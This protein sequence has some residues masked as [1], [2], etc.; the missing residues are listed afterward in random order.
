MTTRQTPEQGGDEELVLRYTPVDGRCGWLGPVLLFGGFAAIGVLG[1]V[2]LFADPDSAAEQVGV[3]GM[4]C[5]VLVCVAAVA[6]FGLLTVRMTVVGW[7]SVHD[8]WW[9]RLSRTGFEVNDRVFRPRRYAWAEI[10]RFLLAGVVI[11]GT[12]VPRVGFHYAP[13]HRHGLAG[14]LRR[15]SGRRRQPDGSKVDVAVMG[16]WDRPFDQAVDLMNEWL[17]RHQPVGAAAATALEQDAPPW[18]WRHPSRN[19]T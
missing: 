13:G 14:R 5:V 2:A 8:D 17:T 3:G 16:Y 9:L 10:D 4:V 18:S 12:P 15:P 11:E 7:R 1:L 19:R 6:L